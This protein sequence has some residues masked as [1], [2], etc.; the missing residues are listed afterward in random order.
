MKTLLSVLTLLTLFAPGAFGA[1]LSGAGPGVIVW[2]RPDAA[3]SC[4]EELR[5]T[6]P[7]QLV[8]RLAV[9]PRGAGTLS[10][11]SS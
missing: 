6:Y 9:T 7:D 3:A 5:G 4:E 2:A 1:T 11:T 8:L 10:V